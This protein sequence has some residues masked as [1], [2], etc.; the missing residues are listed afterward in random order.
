MSLAYFLVSPLCCVFLVVLEI[1]VLPCDDLGLYLYLFAID[2]FLDEIIFD[3]LFVLMLLR[4][5]EA[6]SDAALAVV[7]VADVLV[8]ESVFGA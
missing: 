8:G 4:A 5:L 6:Q 2:T 1:A 7:V 3:I